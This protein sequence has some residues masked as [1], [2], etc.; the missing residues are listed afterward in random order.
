MLDHVRPTRNHLLVSLGANLV[1]ALTIFHLTY[2]AG[3]GFDSLTSLS[4]F[5]YG[6]SAAAAPAATSASCGAASAASTLADRLAASRPTEAHALVEVEDELV[7][8][9]DEEAGDEDEARPHEAAAQAAGADKPDT[10]EFAQLSPPLRGNAPPSLPR[11]GMC[12]VAPRLCDE[13]GSDF[14]VRAIG[15]E[16]SNT[17]L[18]RVLGKMR[19]GEAFTVGVVGGSVSKGHG[20]HDHN[21]PTTPFNMHRIVFD[22]LNGRFPSPYAR[23]HDDEAADVKDTGDHQAHGVVLGASGKGEGKHAFVNGALPATGSNYYSTCF[24]EHVPDDVDL[25]LLE[26]AIND[27]WNSES[28]QTYERLIRALLDLPSQPAIIN[29]HVFALMFDTIMLGGDMHY[30]VS[31]FYDLPIVT[32]RNPVL[33]RIL[34]NESLVNDWFVQEP[35]RVDLRH[36]SRLGHRVLG[37]LVNAYID[38]QLCE[39]DII[40]AE[41]DT[42]DTDQLYPLHPIPRLLL[43]QKYDPQRVVP[44][45]KP[46]CF[47]TN[48]DKS[49]L[50][51]VEQHGW[52]EWSWQDKSYWV[53]DEPGARFSVKFSTG[54]GTVRLYYQRSAEYGLGAVQCWVDDAPDRRATVDGYWDRPYSV[55]Q[56]FTVRND[57]APGEHTLHCEIAEGTKDPKGGKEFRI[58]GVFSF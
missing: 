17:R 19:R 52:R 28:P 47:T 24:G 11:C 10:N 3:T 40:E 53:A 51:P 27:G 30:G 2:S 20:I 6:G 36:V 54:L 22:H 46:N 32:L 18:R 5:G 43:T 39:M 49:K 8:E 42:P 26:M 34:Q 29:M 33:P 4:V 12:D 38:R 9:D 48:A 25:V 57:L 13:F 45:V 16:G 44:A 14:L 35:D 31:T 1:A 37:Q 56:E 23:E 21:E 50:V 55:G 7:A 58:I 15:H 41:A